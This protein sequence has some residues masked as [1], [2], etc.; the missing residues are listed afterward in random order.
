MNKCLRITF[1]A[2]FPEGFLQSFLLKHARILDLEGAAQV[3]DDTVRVIACGTKE[4]VD[5][6]LDM[7]YKGTTQ[8]IPENIEVEAFLKDK[9][10]R[11]VF[12]IIE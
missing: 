4:K 5:E 10:Y 12:R 8:Y 11:G 1:S 7:I 2:G 6:F 3:V 9:D